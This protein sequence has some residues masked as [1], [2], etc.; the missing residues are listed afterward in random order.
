MN[1]RT[2]TTRSMTRRCTRALAARHSS[3]T[4]LEQSLCS[5]FGSRRSHVIRPPSRRRSNAAADHY[6]QQEY[7]TRE[8]RESGVDR[9]TSSTS[10]MICAM[11]RAATQSRR[12]PLPPNTGQK[13]NWIDQR[14][15]RGITIESPVKSAKSRSPV[16]IRGASNFSGSSTCQAHPQWRW[17]LVVQIWIADR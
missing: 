5:E 3:P 4:S 6:D 8:G 14:P 7:A 9:F 15:A 2:A 13:G 11:S 10:D 17:S 1:R 12:S 16:Q